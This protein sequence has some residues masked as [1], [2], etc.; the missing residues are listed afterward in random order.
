MGES[1]TAARSPVTLRFRK[2]AGVQESGS[3]PTRA[4]LLPPSRL[5]CS[6]LCPC[7]R[8]CSSCGSICISCTSGTFIRADISF[9]IIFIGALIEIPAAF[10]LAFGTRYRRLARVAVGIGSGLMLDELVYLVA[11]GASDADYVSRTSLVGSFVF[12]ALA[13]I[14]VIVLFA[15]HRNK[16]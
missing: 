9:I 7:W 5:F 16:S 11:T 14:F 10:L 15:I 13:V 6:S 12:V 2:S 4:Y 8:Q 3:W 1:K